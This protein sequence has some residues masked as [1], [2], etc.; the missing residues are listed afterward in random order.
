MTLTL[1]AISSSILLFFHCIS[2]YHRYE[3]KAIVHWLKQHGT[4]PQTRESMSARSLRPNRALKDLI[5]QS[6]A[7]GI[8]LSASSGSNIADVKGAR[9]SFR[10]MDFFLSKNS[11]RN[12]TDG[13]DGKN[14]GP[15]RYDSFKSANSAKSADSFKSVEKQSATELSVTKAVEVQSI[16]PKAITEE[17]LQSIRAS[18]K[19]TVH[20]NSQNQHQSIVHVDTPDIGQTSGSSHICCV[21]DISGSMGKEAA[22]KDENGMETRTGLNIL[23][24]VKFATLVICKSLEKEDKLS[25]VTYSNSAE[26]VLQPTN[27]DEDGK[28]KVKA[29]LKGIKPK[30]MT[31]LW[32]GMKA[33]IVLA[34]EVGDDYIN[35]VF[36]LTDGIPNVHPPLGYERSLKRLLKNLPLFGTI[37][38]FGFGYSLQSDLL[39]QIAKDGGG[40]FSFIPD[41]GFV[42]TC[43]INAVANARSAYGINPYLRIHANLDKNSISSLNNNHSVVKGTSNDKTVCMKFTPLRFGSSIDLFINKISGLRSNVEIDLVFHVVGGQEVCVPVQRITQTDDI[44]DMLQTTRD[45][46]I[47]KGLHIISISSFNSKNVGAFTPPSNAVSYRGR[48]SD[49]DAL[50]KD[51]E[52]QANEGTLHNFFLSADNAFAFNFTKCFPFPL[53]LKLFLLRNTMNVGVVTSCSPS[54]GLICTSFAITLKIPECK[55]MEA[56]NCLQHFKKILTISLRLS[57]LQNHQ[58][59]HQTITLPSLHLPWEKLLTI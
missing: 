58:T 20:I 36:V 52:G 17:L 53:Y 55:Y 45:N 16:P 7:N 11:K 13:D 27:M 30:A 39:M 3:R 59:S 44:S 26:V 32:D 57:Q 22:C 41:A 33:G 51:L 19:A 28:Q 10:C 50:C 40:Y 48:S 54:S 9:K 18:T 56:V 12:V 14:N 37:S 5:E 31:N 35:S 34:N 29:V 46:F 6:K 38:T 15:Q 23:D 24:V 2:Q 1:Y 42:G 21:M 25:I 47:E 4:S 49:I 8:P 43:F